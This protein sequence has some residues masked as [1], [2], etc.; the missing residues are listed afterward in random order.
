MDDEFWIYDPAIL[1]RA[2]RLVEFYPTVDMS[3]GEKLNSI[4][5]FLLY[6]GIIITGVKRKAWP[7]A[8]ALALMVTTSLMY[9]KEGTVMEGMSKQRVKINNINENYEDTPRDT[10]E[11]VPLCR[12][13][14]QDN[15]FANP[16]PTDYDDANK[17]K[18]ES[19]NDKNF[20]MKKVNSN[21]PYGK[22]LDRWYTIPGSSIPNNRRLSDLE[23][24]CKSGNQAACTGYN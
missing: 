19:C 16:L 22:E 24:N 2:D 18:V 13:S 6:S 4:C 15:P 8:V 17:I 5:R 1:V 3:S 20:E 7:L 11:F 10:Y 14:S 23:D 9:E 21:D 12:S